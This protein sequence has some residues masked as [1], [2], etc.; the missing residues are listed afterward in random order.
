MLRGLLCVGKVC[1]PELGARSIRDRVSLLRGRTDGRYLMRVTP[2]PASSASAM[3]RVL[4]CVG[5]V[6]YPEPAHCTSAATPIGSLMLWGQPDT[7]HEAIPRHPKRFA[8][9]TE[10]RTLPKD[11]G[12]WADGASEQAASSPGRGP[13]SRSRIRAAAS[14]RSTAV[15]TVVLRSA[16]LAPPPPPPPSLPSALVPPPRAS[17]ARRSMRSSCH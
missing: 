7:R 12:P 1:Y 5:K 2:H 10:L 6:C 13:R 17:P 15:I 14:S 9:L 3:L 16:S 8:V 4:L 11:G